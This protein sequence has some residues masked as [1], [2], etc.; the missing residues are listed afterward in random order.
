MVYLF[1]SDSIVE[2]LSK[3]LFPVVIHIDS[4]RVN[5]IFLDKFVVDQDILH[6]FD[7]GWGWCHIFSDTCADV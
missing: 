2:M 6:I 3:T 7:P 1:E 4:N 5:E